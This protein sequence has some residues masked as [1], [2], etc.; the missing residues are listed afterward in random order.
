MLHDITMPSL[1]CRMVKIV[2]DLLDRVRRAKRKAHAR[3]EQ[4]PDQAA[5]P[6][7]CSVVVSSMALGTGTA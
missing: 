4:G 7:Y 2:N 1:L 5:I 3:H 6:A